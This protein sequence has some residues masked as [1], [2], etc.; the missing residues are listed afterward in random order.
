MVAGIIKAGPD[1]VTS[2]VKSSQKI[3]LNYLLHSQ[4]ILFFY[5][6]FPEML[7]VLTTRGQ[8]PLEVMEARRLLDKL[9]RKF[10]ANFDGKFNYT[11]K[12]QIL[13]FNH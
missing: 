13:T 3:L 9:A 8:K 7:K 10:D 6:R 5:Y 4:I 2:G 11:G 12:Q 1:P